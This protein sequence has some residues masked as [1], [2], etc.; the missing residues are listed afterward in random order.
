MAQRNKQLNPAS[1]EG[2]ERLQAHVISRNYGRT[3]PVDEVKYVVARKLGVPLSRGYNGQLQVSSAGK[4]GGYI[5]GRMV[6]EMV[7]MAQ[8]RLAEREQ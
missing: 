7:R 8:Q 2:L 4:V 5:G 1:R 3:I 6:K